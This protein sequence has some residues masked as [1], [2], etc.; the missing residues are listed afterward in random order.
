MELM[1]WVLLTLSGLCFAL[2]ILLLWLGPPTRHPRVD[3][4]PWYRLGAAKRSL[5]QTPETVGDRK[6]HL[7][8]EESAVS[9][10]SGERS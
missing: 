7:P 3:G 4:T 8:D 2:V 1:D 10:T 5:L 6:F 9:Q